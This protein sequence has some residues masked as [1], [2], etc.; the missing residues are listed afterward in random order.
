MDM[1]PLALI[2]AAAQLSVGLLAPSTVSAASK[3]RPSQA[4]VAISLGDGN[5]T[6]SKKSKSVKAKQ[7]GRTKG[8]K[9]R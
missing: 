2:L 9:R 3:G 5:T 4:H 8:V 6:E 7:S 1:R